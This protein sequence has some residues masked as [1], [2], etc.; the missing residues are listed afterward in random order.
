MTR[1]TKVGVVNVAAYLLVVDGACFAGPAMHR[2]KA[3]LDFRHP[4]HISQ[5]F[6]Q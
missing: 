2:A 1:R 4:R 5:K 6:R 3:T